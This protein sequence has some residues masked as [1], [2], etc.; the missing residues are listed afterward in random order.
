[1]LQLVVEFGDWW[2]VMVMIIC[3]TMI[4]QIIRA[5]NVLRIHC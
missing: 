2:L 4:K 5:N 1:M 3:T